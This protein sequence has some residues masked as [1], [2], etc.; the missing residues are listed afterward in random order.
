[1]EFR[2]RTVDR[3]LHLGDD[4]AAFV[5]GVADHVHDA[6]E[7]FRPDGNGDAVA[8]VRDFGA[9]LQAVRGVHGDGAHRVFAQ[10]L[11]HFQDQNAVAEFHMQGVQNRG[12]VARE[13]YVHHGAQNLGH[14]TNTVR[15]HSL[16]APVKRTF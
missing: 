9:A 4:G 15:S 2:G 13:L 1:M 8:R 16:L 12:Q 3:H 6:A 10:V 14:L 5:H 11:R 7:R